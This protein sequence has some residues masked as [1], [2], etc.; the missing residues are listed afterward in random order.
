[1]TIVIYSRVIELLITITE[2]YSS[3]KADGRQSIQQ[4]P[5]FKQSEVHCGIYLIPPLFPVLS[6]LNPTSSSHCFINKLKV[7]LYVCAGYKGVW[8]QK[9]SSSTQQNLFHLISIVKPTRCT[10]VCLLASQQTPVSIWHMPVAV[11]TVLNCWWWT[12]RPSE[13]CRVSS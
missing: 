9:F 2:H 4:I 8:G 10:N 5:Q 12:E 1:M 6:Q 13:T 11:C 3:Y 7:K